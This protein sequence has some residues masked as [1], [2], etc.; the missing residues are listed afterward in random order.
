MQVLSS[1]ALDKIRTIS[2]ILNLAVLGSNMAAVFNCVATVYDILIK[3]NGIMSH[4]LHAKRVLM[5]LQH[6]SSVNFV[7]QVWITPLQGIIWSLVSRTYSTDST[8]FV[9]FDDVAEQ[10]AQM[11]LVD[12]TSTLENETENG[13]SIPLSR[14]VS[15]KVKVEKDD[16]LGNECNASSSS[17]KIMTPNLR[18]KRRRLRLQSEDES[19]D[20]GRNEVASDLEE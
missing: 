2:E 16:T 14:I 20:V 10:V 9:L 3:M 8:I 4:V 5:L 17:P 1:A 19:D 15:P 11:K 13:S 18:Q 12:L 7:M 6:T